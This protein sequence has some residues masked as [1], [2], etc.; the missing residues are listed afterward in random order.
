MTTRE[1]VHLV[2]GSYSPSRNEDGG[3]AI[4]SAV[5]KNAMLHANF[6]SLCVIDADFSPI[7]SMRAGAV[8]CKFTKI[9]DVM[10]NKGYY[11]VQG[12]SRSP[13]LVPIESAY[14]TCY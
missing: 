2:T 10:Q 5:A 4:R 12:H 13:I 6:T 7:S 9:G 8:I 11:A 1:C 3:H 14:A